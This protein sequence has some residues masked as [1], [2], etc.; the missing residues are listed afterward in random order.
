VRDGLFFGPV[1]GEVD[2]KSKKRVGEAVV[3]SRLRGQD[4]PE[5]ERDM[6]P[7]KLSSWEQLLQGVTE[8]EKFHVPTMAAQ[9]IGSVGVRQAE[10][11]RQEMNEREGKRDRIRPKG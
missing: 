9:M 11:P 2:G 8:E 6:L 1:H 5:I 4:L 3:C 7:C 10:I